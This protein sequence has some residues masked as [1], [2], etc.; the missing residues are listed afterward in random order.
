MSGITNLNTEPAEY[1]APRQSSNP[2]MNN[3]KD[4]IFRAKTKEAFVIK[5]LS[6]L[7]SNA[8]IKY[9]PFRIDQEGIHLSQS[10]V[11]N[12]QLINFTLNRENFTGGWRC[13]EPLNFSVNSS[14]LYKLLKAIKKKDTITLFIR[15]DDPLK[16]G[17]CVETQ[18]EN[19]MT[20]TYI[21]LSKCQPEVFNE[22]TGYPTPTITSNKEFQKMKVLHNIS[23]TMLVTCPRPGGLVKFYCDAIEVYQREVILGTDNQDDDIKEDQIE[24]Y[25]Q[26]FHTTHITGLTKC[27]NQ[28]G[29][30]QIYVAPDLPLKFKMKA[31]LLGDLTIFIKSIERINLEKKMAKEKSQTQQ[32]NEE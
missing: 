10:D 14:H 19:N 13:T 18:D 3:P 23:K 21:R 7:V 27:A 26:T 28:S 2:N 16:L 15:H 17:I 5:I 1:V 30:V 24:E 8:H 20:N 29:N 11:F 31:G 6:E 32:E 22:P 9:A 4:Y 12:Q 25:K